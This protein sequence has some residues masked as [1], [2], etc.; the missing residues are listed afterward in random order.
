MH[1]CPYC[2]EFT[3]NRLI[4]NQTLLFRVHTVGKFSQGIQVSLEQK[5]QAT[6][7]ARSPS[8]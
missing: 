6:M 2:G 4:G 8:S 5:T 1:V 7:R 3:G